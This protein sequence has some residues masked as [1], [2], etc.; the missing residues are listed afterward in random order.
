[1][2]T[3]N[4]ARETA[5]RQLDAESKKKSN[6]ASIAEQQTL[7][8]YSFVGTS[9]LCGCKAATMILWTIVC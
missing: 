2:Q 5:Q 7:C 6:K 8:M 9:M 3:L 1:M 4:D